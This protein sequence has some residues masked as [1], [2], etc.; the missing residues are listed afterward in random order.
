VYELV[1]TLLALSSCGHCCDGCSLT[2]ESIGPYLGV[3]FKLL[4][5]RKIV[6]DPCAGPHT[7]RLDHGDTV[8]C[9]WSFQK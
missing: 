4:S 5:I 9:T 2:L 6:C 7:G 3:D 1:R 8:M